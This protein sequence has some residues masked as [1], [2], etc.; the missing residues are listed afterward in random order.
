MT[1]VWMPA[2]KLPCSRPSAKNAI[3]AARS[4]SVTGRRKA[5]RGDARDECAARRAVLRPGFGTADEDLLPTGR[6]ADAAGVEGADDV[7][8]ADIGVGIIGTAGR[9]REQ[10]RLVL[11]K[12]FLR[13]G[14]ADRCGPALTGTR[15]LWNRAAISAAAAAWRWSMLRA[16]FFTTGL[17]GLHALAID[18]EDDASVAEAE[19][20]A[21]T[22]ADA[23]R[24]LV[25]TVGRKPV[26]HQHAAARAQR[27]AFAVRS[28]RPPAAR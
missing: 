16:S 6:V 15:M 21:A 23:Q 26:L 28:L 20:V 4:A 8:G 12:G 5:S 1:A 22:D 27:Q 17:D 10:P 2:S 25:D 19:A 18:R 3:G 7:D 11:G 14:D 24:D 13:E 9:E